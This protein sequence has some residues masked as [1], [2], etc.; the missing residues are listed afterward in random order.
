MTTWGPGVELTELAT[1]IAPPARS[2][3][4]NAARAAEI[5]RVRMRCSC[6]SGGLTHASSATLGHRNQWS[7]V[8]RPRSGHAERHPQGSVAFETGLPALHER[9]AGL[10]EVLGPQ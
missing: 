7:M 4:D 5:R 9:L 10:H 1:A 3:I 6:N 2:G 8:L